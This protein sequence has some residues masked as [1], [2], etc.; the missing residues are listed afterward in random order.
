MYYEISIEIVW[1]SD[2]LMDFLLLTLLGR[3]LN[4]TATQGRIFLGSLFGA[5]AEC[6]LLLTPDLHRS[7]KFLVSYTLISTCMVKIGFQIRSWKEMGKALVFLYGLAFSMGGI[8]MW[9]RSIFPLKH[10]FLCAGAGYLFLSFL[11]WILKRNKEKRK[12][13]YT[14]ELVIGG[15][16]IIITGLL[17]TGNS[18]K[19]P[20]TGKPVSILT[21]QPVLDTIPLTYR[22]IPFHS[23]GKRNGLLRAITADGMKIFQEGE[24]W[25][26]KN[27]V[28]AVVQ[29][30]VSSEGKYELVLNPRLIDN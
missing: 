8:F 13:F 17:D 12:N 24:E 10:F 15:I 22:L 4:C 21:N 27:P 26:I 3:I 20:Y 19:D 9:V 28:I 29:D 11:Q 5:T 14:V 18:L 30:P 2:L 6:L 7:I 23:I 25:N 16:P 1:L